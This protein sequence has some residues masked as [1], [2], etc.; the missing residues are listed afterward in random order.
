MW[1]EMVYNDTI[2]P[3]IARYVQLWPYLSPH[4][5]F[6]SIF[7]KCAWNGYVCL[8]MSASGRYCII[9]HLM[10]PYDLLWSTVTVY[11]QVY[12]IW[13]SYSVSWRNC[14]CCVKYIR[15]W[16]V[17]HSEIGLKKFD[18]KWHK[19]VLYKIQCPDMINYYHISR[20]ITSFVQFW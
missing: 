17:W 19:M 3:V 8:M 18:L 2:C 9:W 4:S 14:E 6:W 12:Q 13:T 1:P 10:V 7:Y 15:L 5:Q 11:G 20:Y 16:H